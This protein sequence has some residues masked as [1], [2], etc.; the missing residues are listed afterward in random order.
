MIYFNLFTYCFQSRLDLIMLCLVYLPHQVDMVVNF[1]LP[2]KRDSLEEPD[3]DLYLR[4][5][6]E[7]GSIF[8]IILKYLL[9]IFLKLSYPDKSFSY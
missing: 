8:V 1:D 7:K 9:H 3:I 2:V 4:R 6:P 5:L